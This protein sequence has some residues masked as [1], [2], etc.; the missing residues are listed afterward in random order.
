M[1]YFLFVSF[2]FRVYLLINYRFIE[3]RLF[4]ITILSV[5]TQCSSVATV[6]NIY[7]KAA[8]YVRFIVSRSQYFIL[9]LS[10]ILCSSIFYATHQQTPSNEPPTLFT[11]TILF[12]LS[13]YTLCLFTIVCT[14]IFYIV[15]VYLRSSQK[16]CYIPLFFFAFKFLFVY[17]C[18]YLYL[19]LTEV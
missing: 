12:E 19:C 10:L 5:F 1:L 6:L 16:I 8:L 17:N 14:F 15:F 13:P 3:F 2:E 4:A 9:R 11:H 7:L 18:L